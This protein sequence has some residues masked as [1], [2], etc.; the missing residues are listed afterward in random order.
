MGRI[1]NIKH[2]QFFMAIG[3]VALSPL[4][5]AGS[6]A[7]V[8]AEGKKL[9]AASV[10][11]EVPKAEPVFAWVNDKAITVSEYKGLMAEI[12][13]K[14]FYHG[15]IPEG[16]AEALYKEISELVT[17]R[18]LLVG[19]ALRRGINPDPAK[20]EKTLAALD[21]R[22]A[23]QPEWKERRDQ[24]LPQ[25]KLNMDRLSLVEELEKEVR[26]VPRPTPSEVRTFYDKKPELFTEPERLRLSVLL[27][28]IDPGATKME[29]DRVRE[30][31]QKIV[32]RIKQGEDFAGQARL[33]SQHESAEKG[34]DLGYLHGGMLPRGLEDRI[35]AFP[36]GVV[37]EP[38]TTL[39]GVIVARVEDRVPP[40]L[41]EF[42]AVE[43]R[44]KDLLVRERAD[45]AWKNLI[46]KLQA[47]AKI[48][49]VT[50]QIP[51]EVKG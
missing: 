23:A 29:W 44:A 39:E 40:K 15:T 41:R 51:P 36:V 24:L 48:E 21:A 32:D 19:E 46:S 6:D 20:Y 5:M 27:L 18:E 33:H 42:T 45:E 8:P 1:R 30:E 26:E 49:I 37:N 50:P 43:E 13:R 31:A 34:G 47:S 22:Y 2:H 28:K 7:S 16:K 25:L 9:Q 12:M 11:P 14:R 4:G 35:G 38:V 3:I 17:D 10:A